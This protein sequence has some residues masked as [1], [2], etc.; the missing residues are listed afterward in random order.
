MKS[1]RYGKALDLANEPDI[2]EYEFQ[3]RME[4]ERAPRRARRAETRDTLLSAIMQYRLLKRVVSELFDETSTFTSESYL[5]EFI[6]HAAA[7][8]QVHDQASAKTFLD[9]EFGP[10]TR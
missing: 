3:Q 10:E 9:M 8:N 1:Y 5:L 4:R 6:E 7:E 2:E